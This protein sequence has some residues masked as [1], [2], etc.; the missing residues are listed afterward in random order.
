M[1]EQPRSHTEQGR[2][3]RP[4]LDRP[5]RCRRGKART[6]T[7]ARGAEAHNS[8]VDEEARPEAAA[9]RLEDESAVV[10]AMANPADGAAMA[11]WWGYLIDISRSEHAAKGLLHAM[12]E[13]TEVGISSG[14]FVRGAVV[15]DL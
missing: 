8:A 10:A 5:L 12:D 11:S 6:E 9:A 4:A 2:R 3:R 13:E 1:A 14:A 7:R 15:F